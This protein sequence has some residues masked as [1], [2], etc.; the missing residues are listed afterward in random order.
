MPQRVGV[1]VFLDSRSLGRF[2]TGIPNRFCVDRLIPTV[3]AVAR[4][5]PALR[6]STHS[7][8]DARIRYSPKTSRYLL[9]RFARS[10]SSHLSNV[11]LFAA[12]GQH[13]REARNPVTTPVHDIG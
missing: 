4:K 11:V 6:L 8:V 10:C 1:H 5:Q 12:I 3:V 7:S 9:A 2:L 13:P